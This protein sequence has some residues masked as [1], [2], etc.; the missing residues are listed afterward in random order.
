MNT[1]P[2]VWNPNTPASGKENLEVSSPKIKTNFNTIGNTYGTDHVPLGSA[3]NTG[4]HNQSTYVTQTTVPTADAVNLRLIT[5]LVGT[6]PQLFAQYPTSSGIT[7]LSQIT[8]ASSSSLVNYNPP[9]YPGIDVTELNLVVSGIILY[10]NIITATVVSSGANFFITYGGPTTPS[11]FPTRSLYVGS[12]PQ[13]S[14]P[15]LMSLSNITVNG[16]T[17]SIIAGSGVTGILSWGY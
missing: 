7:A 8:S 15:L 9:G 1:P 10:L 3:S 16:Y 14:N 5:Q 13:P 6:I 12:M 4:Y 17:V 11:P 2:Q